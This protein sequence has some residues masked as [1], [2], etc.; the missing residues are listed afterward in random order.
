MRHRVWFMTGIIILLYIFL[1]TPIHA[2]E[3]EPPQVESEAAILIEPKTGMVLYEKNATKK[4]Y[5]ASLTKIA[6][7][8]YALENGNLEDVVTVSENAYRTLGSSVYLEVGEEISLK[9]LLE[10][11]LINSGN[12]AGIAI[13]ENLSGNVEQFSKDINN[14]LKKSISVR[15]THFENPHGLYNPNHYTTAEDL[16]R[17]IQYSM[18]NKEF[19]K[20]FGMIELDWDGLKWDTTLYTHHK[21]LREMPYPGVT[22]GKTGYVEEAGYT[23]ATTAKRENL[24]LVVI[25]LNADQQMASY[26]DTMALLD[27]GFENFVLKGQQV[28]AMDQ[29]VNNRKLVNANGL[30]IQEKKTVSLKTKVDLIPPSHVDK[31]SVHLNTIPIKHHDI[32]IMVTVLILLWIKF[33]NWKSQKL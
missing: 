9:H 3:M 7:A 8:I 15:N 31:V 6:T 30:N 14:Y 11:L 17:I 18:K 25:T 27:Y 2:E 10:G 22:G 28:V 4:R 33:H 29:E 32:F 26:Q 5:P 1:A 12:D 16:A 24:E 13:A 19:R 20:L 21:L 23:L